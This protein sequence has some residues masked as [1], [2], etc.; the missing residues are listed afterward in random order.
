MLSCNAKNSIMMIDL[1]VGV[2]L[3]T[4]GASWIFFFINL[5]DTFCVCLYS[6]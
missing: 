2:I 3:N 5:I 6:N 1:S 4:H